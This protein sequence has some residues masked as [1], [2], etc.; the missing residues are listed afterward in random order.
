MSPWRPLLK[1]SWCSTLKSN[2]WNHCN[3]FEDKEPKMILMICRDL[4]TPQHRQHWCNVGR[5]IPQ[6]AFGLI[7]HVARKM[8]VQFHMC[9]FQTHIAILYHDLFLWNCPRVNDTE[10]YEWW[11]NIGSSNAVVPPLASNVQAIMTPRRDTI[12]ADDVIITSF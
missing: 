2:Q 5:T 9:N 3:S 1:S 7:G 11:F 8:W 6:Y 4:T 12:P 10:A